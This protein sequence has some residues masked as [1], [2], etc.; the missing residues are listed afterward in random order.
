MAMIQTGIELQ[1]Q[2]SNVIMDFANGMMQAVNAANNFQSVMNQDINTS[3]LN[4]VQTEIQSVMSELDSLNQVADIQSPTV[5]TDNAT[6]EVNQLNAEITRTQN[7]L[8]QVQNIQQAIDTQSQN[9]SVVPDDILSRV[10]GINESMRQLQIMSEQIAQNPFDMPTEAI[11]AEL[12]SLK[13]RIRETI[14]EQLELNESLSNM[15]IEIEQPPPVVVPVEWQTDSIDIF[16]STGVERFTQEVQSAN[17]MLE[18]L[19]DTQN[20]IAAQAFN[21]NILPPKAFQDMNSLAVRI[22]NVRQRIQTLENNPLNIGSDRAN[23]ELEQ[24]RIQLSQAVEQQNE[25]NSAIDRMDVRG[26][27]AAYLQLSQTIANTETYIRDN[28]NEQGEFNNEINRGT[29]NANELMR[30]IGGIAGAYL[31]V[32]TA[33]T[34]LNTSDELMQTTSRISM[35]NDGLQSTQDL[36]NMVFGSAQDARGSFGD[37]ADVIAR[38]GNNAKD[39]FES[40]A[41]VVDFANLIQKQMVIAGASSAEA[42][43]AMLQL[44]QA[45]GSG[46]LRGDELNSIFEQAPNLI[47]NIADYL[48]VPIGQIRAMAQEGELSADIVKAAIFAASDEINANFESMPMT[49]GQIWTSMGNTAIMAFQP[50]LTRLNEIANSDQFQTFVNDAINAM[51]ILSN[52]LL[53]IFDLMGSVAQFTADNWSVISPIIYTVVGAL[54]AYIIAL[55]IFNAIQ[56]VSA[57]IEAVKVAATMLDTGATFAA[58]AAQYGFNAAL[59]ACPVTWIILAIIALIAL[60][61]ALINWIVKLSG[62]TT[63]AFGVV[64]GSV[65]VVIQAFKNLGIDAA[66]AFLGIGSAV[67]ALGYN[68]HAAFQNSIANVQTVFYGL[69]SVA[70]S[71][72]SQIASA[73]S[74]LPFVD[75]DASGIANAAD[76]YAAKAQ[77]AQDSKVQY[78]NVGDAYMNGATTFDRGSYM[79]AYN[80]GEA[81]GN[82]AAKSISDKINGLNPNNVAYANNSAAD[83]ANAKYN[84][85]TAKNTGD[86]AKAAQKAAQSL[87]VTG[88]NLKYIKDMAER[89]TINRFTTARI[90]VKQT[91]HNNVNNTMDLDGINEYLRSDLEQ[92]MA[93]TAEGVH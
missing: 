70:L 83:L 42:S 30:T 26:A 92:R 69:L 61:A 12:A 20:E 10:Q 6:S 50:V 84:E 73:L 81:W 19:S 91:N 82:K 59:L 66:N 21:T 72:I 38:F 3:S 9:M 31:S 16:T 29:E 13:S 68:I 77:A 2:F 48:D 86:T 43:N 28:V 54:G 15:D 39:A 24:L 62:G 55:G 37:M 93:A 51:V 74:E 52:V 7:I 17:S 56:A 5:S 41:E 90:N 11:E 25:M 64:A 60:L 79:D 35:M 88:E 67:D 89:D 57:G 45:L 46:V 78:Q 47:R 22:D 71:V 87:D 40:S 63:T 1:D 4:D 32:N 85:T 80:S 33:R 36:L 8:E 49:W 65:N 75:F 23:A 58:T 18:R 76:D 44:S 27:N 34:A 53:D 14:Q